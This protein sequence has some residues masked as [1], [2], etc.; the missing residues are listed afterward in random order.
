[1]RQSILCGASALALCASAGAGWSLTASEAWEN[2]KS[3]AEAQ[4]QTLTAESTEA[5]IGALTVRGV[6][7]AAEIE[8]TAVSGTLDEVVF[9]ER[10]DGAVTITMSDSYPMSVA[11][12]PEEGEDIDMDLAIAQD[13][14]VMTAADAD[15]GTQFTY[16][17]PEMV[18]T[19][20][21]L[22]VD[23]EAVPFGMTAT[24]TD[25]SGDY[26]ADAGTEPDIASNFAAQSV[27]VELSAQD[28]SGPGTFDMT[29]TMADLSSTSSGTGSALFSMGDLPALLEEG[30]TTRGDVTFGAT[31]FAVDFEDG[32][33]TFRMTG[34]MDGGGVR[35][36]MDSSAL[37]YRTSYQ[38]FE[39]TAEGSDIPFPQVSGA[40]GELATQI[41]MP[42][43]Q[44]DEPRPFDLRVALEDLTLGEEIWS[45]FDPAGA[46]P[47]EP[48]TLILDLAGRGRWLVDIMAEDTM[49]MMAGPPAEVS[50]LDIEA[51][52]LSL[53][54]A[55]FTGEG[56]FTIDNTT[57]AP[58]G[59]PATDG[60]A[61]FRLTG[62]NQLLDTLVQMGLL[63]Q[64]QAAMTRMMTGM[65]ARPG[66][67]PDELVSEITIRPDG[68]ILANGAPLPF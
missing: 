60:T 3:A 34:S 21:D 14:L 54:G 62:G 18:V 52:R 4:G 44:T 38:G 61:S 43:A 40:L 46:L 42:L 24:L 25:V 13:G 11:I 36:A 57:M 22:S 68:T 55:E 51:M 1:M 6:S 47:R 53:A 7:F 19:V 8:E 2:W 23:G 39:F 48:A 29:V 59:M 49:G 65:V 12:R 30:F 26:L 45:L 63:P 67:G 15:G 33:D 16:A 28:D 32:D 66:D 31:S 35:V 50:Q 17:A 9:T 5:G 64:E 20:S 10:D 27:A 56:G 41:D 37:D 58:N